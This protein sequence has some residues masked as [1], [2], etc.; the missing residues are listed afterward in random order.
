MSQ[1]TDQ[2][3]LTVDITQTNYMPWLEHN[4][5]CDCIIFT[6]KEVNK[7]VESLL[8]YSKF[9]EDFVFLSF[10]KFAVVISKDLPNSDE[11]I[12]KHYG[13][14]GIME[15][16][17]TLSRDILPGRCHRIRVS[18]ISFE[19]DNGGIKR[20][21]KCIKLREQAKLCDEVQHTMTHESGCHWCLSFAWKNVDLEYF[22]YKI[23]YICRLRDIG[24]YKTQFG[25][26]G[27][28]TT[29]ALL[30]GKLELMGENLNDSNLRNNF[31]NE[32]S[33]LRNISID[34]QISLKLVDNKII[35]NNKA[36]VVRTLVTLVS[37]LLGEVD[38][39]K[40]NEESIT[41]ALTFHPNLTKEITK[42][43]EVKFKPSSQRVGEFCAMVEDLENQCDLIDTGR[44]TNDER[45]KTIIKSIII[46]L[47][48]ILK[49]NFYCNEKSSL[50]MRLD[51]KILEQIPG[52]Q[53][54]GVYTTLPV[55]IFYIKGY[56]FFGFHVRFRDLARGGLRTVI[57][58][59]SD[60]A[61]YERKGIFKE[62]YNLALTQQMKNKDIPE[63]GSKGVIYLAP[64]QAKT[65][66]EIVFEKVKIER[67]YTT[68]EVDKYITE[69]ET[70]YLY[71]TQRS[72]VKTL[73]SLIV[74]KDDAISEKNIVDYYG[75]PEPIYLGPDENLH[76]KM[77]EWIAQESVRQQY[78]AGAAFISGKKAGINHK[79]YG[80]TSLGVYQYLLEGLKA[81]GLENKNYTLKMTGGPDGDVGGNLLKLLEK[82]QKG[83]VKVNVIVDGTGCLYDPLGVDLEVMN[84]LFK[85][86]QGIT[87]YPPDKLNEGGYIVQI[88]TTRVKNEVSRETLRIKKDRGTVVEE[89]IP[90]NE[91]IRIYTTLAHKTVSDVFIPCGGRPRT[92]RVDNVKDF[93]IEDV[94][95]AK[96][97]IEGANL[98]ETEDARQVLE[99][100]GVLIFKDSSANKCGVIS[101][102]FEILAGLVLTDE[103]FFEIK[104]Q[105]AKEILLKLEELARKE[106][107]CMIEYKVHH[108]DTLM[109]EISI[110]VSQKINKMTD[111]IYGALEPLDLFSIKNTLLLNVVVEYLPPTLKGHY[112]ELT[113]RKLNQQHMKAI[114]AT[115]IACE[116]VY[117]RGLDWKISVLDIIPTLLAQ[118]SN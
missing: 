48:S 68:A 23:A 46:A 109:S 92:L 111:R 12:L 3:P 45:R 37:Q 50:G 81:I 71:Q 8:G 44:K 93:F 35:S 40:Y 38:E 26:S 107:R 116:L 19:E 5:P 79:K 77:I 73:L 11:T 64:T 2:T 115:S 24:I 15:Y 67:R 10:K 87:A 98:Y 60:Q 27:I 54:T 113:L 56:N 96:L 52:L 34:D 55:G 29:Q 21:E 110:L 117:G 1:S 97:I 41:E 118:K 63:G 84:T 28:L 25:M 4:F 70:E 85:V 20:L 6:N 69:K 57:T 104:D 72:Y 43:F 36:M 22:M 94:P 91:A 99:K 14:K 65:E 53:K 33:G 101:S 76:D 82:Y 74:M 105:Y 112:L 83:R 108:P 88:Q 89:Y 102:S 61:K 78:F 32:F 59:D 75:R 7:V 95:T 18:Y 66:S 51:P 39:T 16:E 42:A 31:I 103:E 80:V 100:S 86:V 106:A 58:R 30:Y 49:T 114:I 47:K 17:S 90:S 9:F 62:C 13:H